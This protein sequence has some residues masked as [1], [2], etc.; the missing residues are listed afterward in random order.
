MRS[1]ALTKDRKL[2][3]DNSGNVGQVT[4]LKAIVQGCETAMRAQLGEMYYNADK[5]IP[6]RGTVWDNYNPLQF[7]AAGRATLLAVPGV[8]GVQSFTTD[9]TDDVFTYTAVVNTIYGPGEI[10][11]G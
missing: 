6:T 10:T 9:R 11:N 1:L 2:F 4:G 5:G 7:T 8:L 3:I